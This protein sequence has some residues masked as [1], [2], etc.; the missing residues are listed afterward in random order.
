[1]AVIEYLEDEHPAGF[2]GLR[3]V[4]T[5]GVQ[6]E[7]RQA[8]FSYSEFTPDKA[9]IL[10]D[11][12][13]DEWRKTAD[14]QRKDNLLHR[15]SVRSASIWLASGLRAQIYI[16]SKMRREGRKYYY[17]PAFVI[18]KRPRKGS[19]CFRINMSNG[20]DIRHAY[21]QAVDKYIALRQIAPEQRAVLLSRQPSGQDF[22]MLAIKL[23]LKHEYLIDINHIRRRVG[24]P[25]L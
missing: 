10:A 15:P 25:E 3:V 19:I 20:V 5:L 17:Y 18:D 7:Y 8:Y 23:A 6:E 11:T 9:R 22:V 14:D 4:T 16:E 12:L 24:V 13:H 21:H 2:I 1:M